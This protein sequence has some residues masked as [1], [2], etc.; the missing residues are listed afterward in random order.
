MASPPNE[1]EVTGRDAP[2]PSLR[3]ADGRGSGEA[4]PIALEH[5]RD[6]ARRAVTVENR[7]WHKDDPEKWYIVITPPPPN[8][9]RPVSIAF[10]E[11]RDGAHMEDDRADLI[12]AI[13]AIIEADRE[14]RHG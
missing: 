9:Q 13:A 10:P 2:S 4:R 8:H 6:V 14:A 3:H 12:D 5:P 1:S 11:W 7:K